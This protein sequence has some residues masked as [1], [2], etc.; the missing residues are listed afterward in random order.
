MVTVATDGAAMYDS[1]RDRVRSPRLRRR[2]RRPVAAGETFGALDARRRTPT[3]CWRRRARTG[4]ASSTWA[5]TPGSSSRACSSR[6]SAPAG[7]PEFWTGLRGSWSRLGRLIERVQRAHR[8]SRRPARG[9]GEP[10]PAASRARLLGLRRRQRRRASRTR[11]AARTRDGTTYDHVL[12]RRPRPRR[13]PVS[14]SPAASGRR[15]SSPIAGSCTP[16]TWAWPAAWPTRSSCELVPRLDDALRHG[17]RAWVPG[18][19]RSARADRLSERL[20]FSAPRRGLGQGRDRQ[21]RR[22]AQGSSSLIG[23]AR[24]P[25]GRRADRPGCVPPTDQRWPSPAAATPP[26][27]QPS[28]PRGR[29][30]RLRVFVPADADP[31]VVRPAAGPGRRVEVCPR[32]RGQSRAIPP[33]TGSAAAIA[34]GRPAVHLPG[35]RERARRRGRLHAGLR[36]RRVARRRFAARWLLGP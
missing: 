33:T 4:T 30:R 35:Q 24:P 20:G 25:R 27:R 18:H 1:E 34:S 17:R 8:A 19:A 26:L 9:R 28:S 5:T 10:A 7:D 12:R 23:R 6:T 29:E 3:T 22:L 36:D 15:R 13:D 31:H 11:S 2:L 21:R 14:R 32:Q 16:T